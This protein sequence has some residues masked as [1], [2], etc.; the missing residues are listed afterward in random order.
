M[1]LRDIFRRAKTSGFV[2]LISLSFTPK[3]ELALWH[4]LADIS[5][6]LSSL[7][8]KEREQK[9]DLILN[10][11]NKKGW[12][13]DEASAPDVHRKLLNLT[14]ES[15]LLSAHDH[16]PLT[17]HIGKFF[18]HIRKENAETVSSYDFLVSHLDELRE[19]AQGALEQSLPKIMPHPQIG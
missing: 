13:L 19:A 7:P 1:N 10:N 6:R 5:S 17:G 12:G 8:K 16:N 15:L 4:S 11:L 9:R 2:R 14:L 3:D 18:N